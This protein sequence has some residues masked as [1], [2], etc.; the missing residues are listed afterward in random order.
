MKYITA[1]FFILTVSLLKAQTCQVSSFEMSFFQPIQQAPATQRTLQNNCLTVYVVVDY[2]TYLDFNSDISAVTNWVNQSWD[3]VKPI[4]AADGISVI[5]SDI[6]I[7]TEPDWI[8]L[9][10]Y[11][12]INEV[13]FDFG[14]FIK[15]D[16][17]GRFKHMMTTYDWGGGVAWVGGYCEPRTAVYDQ[18]GLLGY[19]GA[20]AVSGNLDKTVTPYPNYSWNTEVLAHEMGHNLGLNH[21]HDCV[22]GPNMDQRIDDCGGSGCSIIM[23]VEYNT[24]MSYCDNVDLT[25]GFGT[26][27]GI[28]LQNNVANAK[29]LEFTEGTLVLQG[30]LD[31]YEYQAQEIIIPNGGNSI[32]RY[33]TL[34]ADEVTIEKNGL[35][36]PPFQIYSN[37]CN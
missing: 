24:V 17:N 25:L 10:T 29:C 14:G 34:R 27:P 19:Y 26:L 8:T 1:I 3:Q 37:T 15:D 33:L 32:V 23:P 11:N 12:N 9:G 18:N 7:Y 31:D 5:V 2:Y 6:K 30:L 28:R 4:F 35:F 22:W 20:Y 16:V 36:F 21:T 13:L